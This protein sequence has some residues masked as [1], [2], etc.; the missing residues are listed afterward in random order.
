MPFSSFCFPSCTERMDETM[1]RKEVIVM[2]VLIALLAAVTAVRF[3]QRRRLERASALIVEEGNRRIQINSAGAADLE[4][5]PGIGPALARRIIDCRERRGG[6]RRLEEL[7]EVRGI[8]DRLYRRI[9]P[10][11]EL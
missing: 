1:S 4:V 11:L 6:F 10:Y 7:Q 9:S 5:L 3:V 8:G 2:A